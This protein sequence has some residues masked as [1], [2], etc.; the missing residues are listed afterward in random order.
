MVGMSFYYEIG[1]PVKLLYPISINGEMTSIYDYHGREI[2]S[3]MKSVYLYTPFAIHWHQ[4]RNNLLKFNPQVVSYTS[5][6]GRHFVLKVG[7]IAIDG[8]TAS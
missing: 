3:A 8:E 1:V 2:P 7:D 5:I 6:L 4:W